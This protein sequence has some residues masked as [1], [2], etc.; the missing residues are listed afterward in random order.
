MAAISPVGCRSGLI[1]VMLIA[2][3]RHPM[4]TQVNGRVANVLG[5][6]TV[7]LMFTAAV[8]LIVTS[9]RG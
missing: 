3:D 8:A 5:W 1:V 9:S 2:N 6:F 7:A 4:G